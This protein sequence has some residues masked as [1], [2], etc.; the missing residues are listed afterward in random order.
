V[1][2][3]YERY[4]EANWSGDCPE[5]GRSNNNL[6]IGCTLWGRCDFHLTKW[7]REEM[8]FPHSGESE[9]DWRRNAEKVASYREVEP[10]FRHSDILV[11]DA[12]LVAGSVEQIAEALLLKLSEFPAAIATLAIAD[13]CREYA[14]LAAMHTA[15]ARFDMLT[16]LAHSRGHLGP[17]GSA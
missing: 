4:P 3:F 8:P 17:R 11:S 1:S 12:S 13:L 16:D 2:E 15:N 10:L 5:C 7:I 9:I 6:A 14:R